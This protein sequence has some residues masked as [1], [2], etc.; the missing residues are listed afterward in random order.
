MGESQNHFGLDSV[1][2]QQQLH[3]PKKNAEGLHLNQHG[4]DQAQNHYGLES[5]MMKQQL[6]APKK[7][8]DG[9]R[10]NDRE[11]GEGH[12]GLDAVMVQAAISKFIYK[13]ISARSRQSLT[14]SSFY[15]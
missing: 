4:A 7:P 1:I 15:I 14:N 9:L 11:T 2:L 8:I 5:V 13:S 12:Y 6:N 10:L 3:V